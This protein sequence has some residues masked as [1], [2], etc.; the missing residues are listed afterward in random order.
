VMRTVCTGRGSAGGSET[1]RR[2]SLRNVVIGSTLNPRRTG[3][4]LARNAT[5]TTNTK[6]P[7]ITAHFSDQLSRK[8]FSSA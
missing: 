8:V 7:P 2:Q 1:R 3:T 5:P 4:T 6:A